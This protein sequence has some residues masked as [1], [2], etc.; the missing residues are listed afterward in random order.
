MRKIRSRYLQ[1]W[2]M[3]LTAGERSVFFSDDD[4]GAILFLMKHQ[5]L[6]PAGLAGKCCKVSQS[7]KELTLFDWPVINDDCKK[8]LLIKFYSVPKREPAGQVKLRVA[9]LLLRL[10]SLACARLLDYRDVAKTRHLGGRTRRCLLS[11]PSPRAF[12]CLSLDG[13]RLQCISALTTDQLQY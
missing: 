7:R 9:P 1:T 2:L 6:Q 4:Y 13:K 11:L 8:L 3:C 10:L 12:F 5:P